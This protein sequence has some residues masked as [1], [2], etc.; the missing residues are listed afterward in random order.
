MSM[1]F[2]ECLFQQSFLLNSHFAVNAEQAHLCAPSSIAF[3]HAIQKLAGY[4]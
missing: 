2:A 4:S 1:I 3:N